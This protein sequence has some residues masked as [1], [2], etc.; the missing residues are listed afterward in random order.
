LR[1]HGWSRTGTLHLVIDD[2]Q[3]PAARYRGGLCAGEI[4]IAIIPPTGEANELVKRSL[5]EGE[6][7]FFIYDGIVSEEP[8]R[9]TYVKDKLARLLEGVGL[10][11]CWRRAPPY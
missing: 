11:S 4:R 6:R 8:L 2:L 9:H 1:G 7:I 5:G 10:R 3:R